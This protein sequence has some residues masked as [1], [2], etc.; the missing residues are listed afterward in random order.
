MKK[1]DRL[2][3]IQLIIFALLAGVCVYLVFTNSDLYHAISN[4]PDTRLICGL[5]WAI[6]GLSFIFI[7]IDFVLISS[8]KK[9]YHELDYAVHSDSVAGIANRNSF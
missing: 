9:D 7:F 1:F 2:K 3:T 5:L 6:L 4:N 8:Y